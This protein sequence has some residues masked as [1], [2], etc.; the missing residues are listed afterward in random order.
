MLLDAMHDFILRGRVG[1][2]IIP[3]DDIDR[4]L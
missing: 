3:V 2:L 1:H 4:T